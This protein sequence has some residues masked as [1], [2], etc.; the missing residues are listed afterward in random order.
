MQSKCKGINWIFSNLRQLFNKLSHCV[1]YHRT[2][3]AKDLKV[4][5]VHSLQVSLEV[6]LFLFHTY[7]HTNNLHYLR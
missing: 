2:L 4:F 6:I 5:K 1:I 7:I 3:L